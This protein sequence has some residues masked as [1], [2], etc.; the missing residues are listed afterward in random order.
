V[1]SL[2]ER[3]IREIEKDIQWH[4]ETLDLE[5]GGQEPFIAKFCDQYGQFLRYVGKRWECSVDGQHWVDR[6]GRVL[7]AVFGN[8]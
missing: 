4:E 8:S 5:E 7:S 1:R 6:K 2:I 3:E